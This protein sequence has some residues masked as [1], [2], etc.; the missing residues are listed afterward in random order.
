MPADTAGCSTLEHA[1]SYKPATPEPSAAQAP[2]TN[3]AGSKT[4]FATSLRSLQKHQGHTAPKRVDRV[5]GG[6]SLRLRREL[7]FGRSHLAR[8]AERRPIIVAQRLVEQAPVPA[9]PCAGAPDAGAPARGFFY[10]PKGS[11]HACRWD[12]LEAAANGQTSGAWVPWPLPD[13]VT[14]KPPLLRRFLN[15]LGLEVDD[16]PP[17]ETSS[18]ESGA[19]DEGQK[20]S[21]DTG[22]ETAAKAAADSAQKAV[23]RYREAVKWFVVTAGAIAAAVIGTAPLAGLPSAIERDFWGPATQGFLVTVTALVFILLVVAW[24]IQPLEKSTAELASS[25]KGL[26]H[27]RRKLQE[28]Y[29]E[30]SDLFLDGRAATLQNFRLY[31]SAWRAI[32]ADID[33]QLEREADADR[34]ARLKK[35]LAA[36]QERI[37]RDDDS[38]DA[39][40]ARGAVAQ[41]AARGRLAIFLSALLSFCAA[42]GFVVYLSGTV[43]PTNPVI[44]DLSASE[45]KLGTSL[46][47]A[48]VASGDGLEYVWAHNGAQVEDG[49]KYSGSG[50]RKLVVR[51]FQAQDAG[52]YRVTVK[53][54]AHNSVFDEVDIAE[55]AKPATT[56]ST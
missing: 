1:L 38:V 24:T 31:R 19:H 5:S 51:D 17:E 15:R 35:Y 23:D 14:A 16:D 7:R 47:L 6:L 10:L 42:I 28:R 13:P 8:P 20:A 26:L 36:A 50:T 21:D 41:A 52:T 2:P 46:T 12:P 22:G 30:D 48:A 49:A 18:G 44:T 27:W 54:A 9:N 3:P 43:A 11:K 34:Y 29:A 40:L 32:E 55:P 37:K 56:G 4:I 53:D 25:K 39:N 45:P 33:R